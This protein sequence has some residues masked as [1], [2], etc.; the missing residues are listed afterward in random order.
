MKEEVYMHYENAAAEFSGLISSFNQIE[1]NSVPFEG[2]WTA[3]QVGI[4]I[5]K[6][7]QS[8]IQALTM[9][10]QPVDRSPD[11]R[12]E[13]LK[14]V[15][16]NFNKKLKSPDFILPAPGNYKKEKLV[17]DINESMDELRAMA[18]KVSL[19]GAIRH[20]AFGDITKLELVHFV[21]YHIRRHSLQLKKI[22]DT[23]KNR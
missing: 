23:L 11:E 2:S 5:L 1:L 16:L 3:A 17:K 12:V 4:H 6:S 10:A 14:S 21:V 7:N 22:L 8:I 13:E 18:K 19:S 9:E 15:F 20:T